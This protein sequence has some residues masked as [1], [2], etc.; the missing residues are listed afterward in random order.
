MLYLT[1]HPWMSVLLTGKPCVVSR[2]PFSTIV[3]ISPMS[4]SDV[5]LKIISKFVVGVCGLAAEE[6]SR[7]SKQE[8]FF[9]EESDVIC[10][11]D[12]LPSAL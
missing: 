6:P 1:V 12:I 5:T 10:I 2:L 8:K 9:G 11:F 3:V 7:E 4:I